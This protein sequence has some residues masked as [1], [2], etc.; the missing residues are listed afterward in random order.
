LQN[1][2]LLRA[3]TAHF[4]IVPSARTQKRVQSG[5]TADAARLVLSSKNMWDLFFVMATVFFFAIA[6]LYAEGCDRL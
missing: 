2:I 6:L 1:A 3:G 5:T 4:A